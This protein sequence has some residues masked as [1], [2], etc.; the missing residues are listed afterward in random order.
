MVSKHSQ[1]Y[2]WRSSSKLRVS[3]GLTILQAKLI[4]MEE[5][6]RF[7]A[8]HRHLFSDLGIDCCNHHGAVCCFELVPPASPSPEQL[9]LRERYLTSFTESDSVMVSEHDGRWG[10]AYGTVTSVL[11]GDNMYAFRH[12][13]SLPSL[14]EASS[15][16]PR[17]WLLITTAAPLSL[18]CNRSPLHQCFRIDKYKSID[19]STI[20]VNNLVTFTAHIQAE[21]PTT[22]SQDT[23]FSQRGAGLNQN[24]TQMTFPSLK[25]LREVIIE[26]DPPRFTPRFHTVEEI[27]DASTAHAELVGV[28]KALLAR[29]NE[30]QLRAILR[31]F[32]SDDVCIVQGL[33]GTGKTTIIT[34]IVLL[35]VL[36]NQRVLLSSH[37]HTAIDNVLMKLL[38]YSVSTFSSS[39]TELPVLRL[40]EQSRIHPSIRQYHI[41]QQW[42][43]AFDEYAQIMSQCMVVGATVYTSVAQFPR[44]VV[45]DRCIVDEAGQIT[46]PSILQVMM[47]SRKTLLVGD[48]MQ[49]PPLVQSNLMS[50]GGLSESLLSRLEKQHPACAS[51]LCVQYRMN[52]AI[53]ALTN[54]LIYHNCLTTATTQLA[55]SVLAVQ[56][57]EKAPTWVREVCLPAHCVVFVNTDGWSDENRES[58]SAL[59]SSHQNEFEARITE[60]LVTWM[61]DGGVA[62][63]D[64]GVIS[65]YS[66]QVSLLSNR[67][68]RF[69]RQWRR[70]CCMMGRHKPHGGKEASCCLEVSTVDRFQGRDKECVVVSLVRSNVEQ[71]VRRWREIEE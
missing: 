18:P 9:A 54:H 70:V 15:T 57:S 33:P 40:G 66:A 60:Q 28:V 64:I 62:C 16:D 29:C 68:S 39:H 38:P 23:F 71:N 58:C 26:G 31:S 59:L 37:T 35:S 46:E 56:L 51:K 48:S 22:P 42:S 65:P 25:R 17:V 43:G 6:S 2:L 44:G 55:S 8:H 30:D 52:E 63:S 20:A 49:L 47:M 34:I 53:M 4:F 10:I 11:C 67:L 41:T 13:S 36:Q 14:N 12:H 69:C 3:E 21:A 50:E 7:D 45:F 32:N 5:C 61:V 1:E 27:L 24:N 19:T